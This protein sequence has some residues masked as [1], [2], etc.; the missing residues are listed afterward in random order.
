MAR[1][2]MG[3]WCFASCDVR[4]ALGATAWTA[5]HVALLHEPAPPG[6]LSGR[7]AFTT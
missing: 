1:A 7:V 2:R 5:E 6:V 3:A 4:F